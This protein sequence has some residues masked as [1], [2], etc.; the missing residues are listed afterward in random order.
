[1]HARRHISNISEFPAPCSALTPTTFFFKE[2][3][4]EHSAFMSWA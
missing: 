4:A 3:K 2:I 1:M